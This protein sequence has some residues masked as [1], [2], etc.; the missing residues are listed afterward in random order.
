[1]KRGHFLEVMVL[2]NL[3]KARL[4]F[5]AQLNVVVARLQQ[6]I[7]NVFVVLFIAKAVAS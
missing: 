5:T 4:N 6:W 2:S 3:R 1:M 7:Y